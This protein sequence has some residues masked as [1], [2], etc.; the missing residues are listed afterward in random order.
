MGNGNLDPIANFQL[1][2]HQLADEI[3][4]INFPIVGQEVSLAEDHFGAMVEIDWKCREVYGN[5]FEHY[6]RDVELADS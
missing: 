2:L 6:L 3:R 4:G 1:F 5:A